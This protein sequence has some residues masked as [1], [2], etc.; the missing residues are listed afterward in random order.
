MK[1]GSENSNFD[2]L[3]VYSLGTVAFQKMQSFFTNHLHF[4]DTIKLHPIKK[5]QRPHETTYY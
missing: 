4:D 5:L 1:T 3:T 2:K